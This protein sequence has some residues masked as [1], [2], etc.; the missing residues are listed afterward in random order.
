MILGS[1]ALLLLRPAIAAERAGVTMPDQV[2][3]AGASLP[4][5]GLALRE[6]LYFDQYLVGLYFPHR[7]RPARTLIEAEEPKSLR[8][9]ILT[10]E[11]ST[12]SLLR[13]LALSPAAAEDAGLQRLL[14]WLP[15]LLRQGDVLCFD[16]EPGLGTT[17]SLNGTARGRVEGSELMRTF[18]TAFLGPQAPSTLRRELLGGS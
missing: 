15:E 3:L 7:G 17:L 16:Y 9:H 6:R 4:L 14:G 10:R 13:G 2:E 1:L 11:L 5:H 18:W 12:E 8:L